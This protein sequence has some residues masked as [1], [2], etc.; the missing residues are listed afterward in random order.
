[1]AFLH[2]E[3]LYARS[4]GHVKFPRLREHHVVNVLCSPEDG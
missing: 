1:M 3:V 2:L 4:A